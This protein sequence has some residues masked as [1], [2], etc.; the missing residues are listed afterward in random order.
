MTVVLTH[1]PSPYQVELFNEV[2]RQQP[3]SL[4]V[5]YLFRSAEGRSWTGTVL[6]HTHAYLDDDQEMQAGA[7][8]VARADFVVFN[9]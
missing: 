6:A 5:L 2:E 7:A 9:Y 1:F 3:G 8:D 4:N